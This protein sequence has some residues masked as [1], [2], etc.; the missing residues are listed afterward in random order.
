MRAMRRVVR[1]HDVYAWAR[2]F[3]RALGLELAEP[4]ESDEPF[5]VGIGADEGSAPPAA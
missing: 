1:T 3:L 5:E 4:R 2:S